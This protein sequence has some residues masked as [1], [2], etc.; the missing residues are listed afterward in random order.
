LHSPPEKISLAQAG[1]PMALIP[2]MYHV[3]P[4]LM[5]ALAVDRN[6]ADLNLKICSE[7]VMSI[8]TRTLNTSMASQASTDFREQRSPA[9]DQQ[10]Y[11]SPR[12]KVGTVSLSPFKGDADSRNC[13]CSEIDEIKAGVVA[14]K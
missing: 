9:L 12:Q 7:M 10:T 1:R 11:I 13:L 14:F 8:K 2:Q 6:N 3:T 4:L 5:L